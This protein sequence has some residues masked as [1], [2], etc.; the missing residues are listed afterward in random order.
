[1]C[2]RIFPKRQLY[3]QISSLIT[4]CRYDR[5]TYVYTGKQ[6]DRYTD[7]QKDTQRDRYMD[8]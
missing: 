2:I 4:E 3:R 7:R 8:R 5:K 1:M 6:T